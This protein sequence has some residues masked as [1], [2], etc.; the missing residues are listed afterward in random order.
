MLTQQQLDEFDR[1]GIVQIPNAIPRADA[2]AMCTLVWDNLSRRYPFRRDQPDTW[3]ATRVNGF[4]ALDKS[5][6]FEQVGSPAVCQM[7]DA[8]LGCGNWQRPE[9]WGSLLVTFPESRERWDVPHASWHLDFPGASRLVEGLFSVRIFTCLAPLPHGGGGTVV[10]AGSHLLVEQLAH[11]TS[12]RLRSA[13]ARNAL[14]RAHPWVKALCSR[15]ETADRIE[16]F[17]NLGTTV[18]GTELRVVE[19]TGEPGDIYLA[20]PRILHAHTTNCAAAPRIVLSS[21]IYRNGVDPSP[22]AGSAEN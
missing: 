16:R 22:L 19:M 3:A 8:L 7:L 18:D 17:M 14:M 13:D 20:H 2:E 21:F 1:R 12:E 6:A 10:L 5:V 4:N 9:R 11:K 15:D